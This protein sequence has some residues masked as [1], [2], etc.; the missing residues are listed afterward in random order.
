MRRIAT[1]TFLLALAGALLAGGPDDDF[2]AIYT[3]I[4]QADTLQKGGQLR[5]AATEYLHARE[6]LQKLHADFPNSNVAAVNYRLDYLADKLKELAAYV[7]SSSANA[8]PAKP[9][10]TLTPQ[11]QAQMWQEEISAL[12]NAA[13]QLEIQTNALRQKINELTAANSQLQSKLRE[14]L[15][16]QPA[17]VAPAEMAKLREQIL[18]LQKDRD[19]LRATLDQFK[20]G[21]PAPK[22]SAANAE[23]ATPPA[24]I[25][26]IMYNLD[27][28]AEQVLHEIYARLVGRTQ[29]ETLTGPEAIDRGR[30]ISL[31]TPSPVT[32]STAIKALETVMAANGITIVPVGDKFFK[33]VPNKLE[34]APPVERPVS[35][36]IKQLTAER[37]QLKKDLAAAK[38]DLDSANRKTEANSAAASNLKTAEKERDDL[39]KELVSANRKA[40]ASTAEAAVKIKSAEKERDDLKKQIAATKT[41]APAPRTASSGGSVRKWKVCA[42]VWRC[43]KPRRCPIQPKNWRC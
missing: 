43:W 21:K 13:A 6:A 10:T 22:P 35:D 1:L 42:R 33:A 39:K 27:M 19:L 16:E 2:L 38:K 28:P 9:A 40:D 15:A 23:S 24:E 37:D 14:A 32:K 34:P 29:I 18:S 30:L 11:Q 12:T 31:H 17:A 41:S 3:Q 26:D 20:A 25:A 8:A 7:P 5:E 4:Q 36:N